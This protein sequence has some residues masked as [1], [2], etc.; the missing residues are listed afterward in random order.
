MVVLK[1]SDAHF[2]AVDGL[3]AMG[4]LQKKLAFAVHALG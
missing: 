4:S 2:G 1:R 3:Q